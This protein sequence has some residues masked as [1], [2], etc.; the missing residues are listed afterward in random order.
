MNPAQAEAL[1]ALLAPTG[2]PD[3]TVAFAR[4]LRARART[5]HGLL[6]NGT[7]PDEPWQQTPHLA[8][9]LSTHGCQLER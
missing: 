6:V 5:P 2:W 3:L 9:C 4:A 8:D 7:P 1:R